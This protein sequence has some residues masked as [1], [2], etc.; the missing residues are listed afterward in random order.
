[1]R[2]P[3]IIPG[4]LVPLL[5]LFLLFAFLSVRPSVA[6]P[7][8]DDVRVVANL[9]LE[10]MHVNQMFVQQRGGRTYLYLHRPRK[11]VFA[12]VDVTKPD[13]PVLVS[14]HA[15]KG[16]SEGPAA[17]SAFAITVAPEAMDPGAK[18]PMETVNLVDASHPK[19]IKTIKTFTGV[20]S[21]YNDD[22][23]KLVYLVNGEGLWIVSHR[24]TRPV[25]ICGTEE[26]SDCLA[27]P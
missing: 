5:S 1:M 10:G 13:K 25:S 3:S 6:A 4:R 18:L 21:M 23:R 19:A 22:A 17:G 24:L 14:R 7:P 9:P 8:E 16:S 27:G 11:D 20:T 2:I 12:L 15:L 26:E